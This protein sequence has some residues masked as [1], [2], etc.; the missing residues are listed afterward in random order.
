MSDVYQPP[1][2]LEED[3]YCNSMDEYNKRHKE[4]IEDPYA[5]WNPI[6]EEFHWKE[7]PTKENFLKYNFN[8]NDGPISIEW[9]RDGKLNICYNSLDRHIEK[10]GSQV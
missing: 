5:F 3:A 8:L 1:K 10:R 6:V 7:Y 2:D 4:S 9:M